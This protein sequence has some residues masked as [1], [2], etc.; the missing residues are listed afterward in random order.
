M[1]PPRELF[2]ELSQSGEYQRAVTPALPGDFGGFEVPSETEEEHFDWGSLSDFIFGV[3]GGQQLEHLGGNAELGLI[4][5]QRGFWRGG[6]R[7][8]FAV[9]HQ[10]NWIGHIQ[11]PTDRKLEGR[12]EDGNVRVHGQKLKS[13]EAEKLNEIDLQSG[14]TA[15]AIKIV[16]HGL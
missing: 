15:G 6:P 4:F 5:G 1:R 7:R 9:G 11:P 16:G 12:N 3:E 14:A 2:F 8:V 13:R 10:R